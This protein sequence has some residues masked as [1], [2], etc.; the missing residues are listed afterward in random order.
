MPCPVSRP[1]L[2]RIAELRKESARIQAANVM[3]SSAFA[4]QDREAM[5]QRRAKRLQ[6][7]MDELRTMTERKAP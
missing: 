5:R 1:I 3:K 2:E 7:I 4:Y 6:E